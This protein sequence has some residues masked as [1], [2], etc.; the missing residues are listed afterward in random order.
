MNEFVPSPTARD[1][2]IVELLGDVG[3]LH[4][5]IKTIP[6]AL[7]VSMNDTLMLVA[8]AVEDA[9]KTA[10][11]LQTNTKDLIQATASKAGIDVGM[12]LADSIHRSLEKVFEPALNRAATKIEALEKKVSSLSGQVRDTHAVRWN[13]IMLAGFIVVTLMMLAGMTYLAVKAQDAQEINRWFW[14]EYKA[15]RAIIETLPPDIKRKFD[16]SQI[17]E[18]VSK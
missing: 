15:Q 3:R 17:T 1:H 2:L 12:E 6:N 8:N 10:H 16:K 7:K 4:D 11:Q 14:S 5:E 13:Y 9:E 18:S